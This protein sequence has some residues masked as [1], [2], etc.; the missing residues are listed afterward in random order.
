M[1]IVCYLQRIGLTTEC[2]DDIDMPEDS[3]RFYS[4]SN[5]W[6][7]SVNTV[8]NSDQKRQLTFNLNDILVGQSVGCSVTSSGEL[9]CYIDGKFQCVGWTGLPTDRPYWGVAEVY[10]NTTKIKSE[11]VFSKFFIYFNYYILNS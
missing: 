9:H 2:P 3:L 11:F 7:L 1:Y 4:S 5:Y 10:A 8:Y 6:I